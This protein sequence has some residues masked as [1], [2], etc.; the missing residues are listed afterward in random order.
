MPGNKKPRKKI[1]AVRHRGNPVGAAINA[2]KRQLGTALLLHESL[3]SVLDGSGSDDHIA[4]LLSAVHYY[5]ALIDRV[6]IDKTIEP[7]GIAV[8]RDILV[9][10][11]DA[12]AGV[13]ERFLKIGR[14][15]CTGQE[16]KDLC[17]LLELADILENETTLA[18]AREAAQ[19]LWSE[20]TS[21]DQQEKQS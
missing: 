15:G 19:R 18:Q 12:V 2:Q 3:A 1:R 6:E 13:Q 14:V 10:A 9:D 17:G 11:R 21:A 8:A 16:R 4:V 20:L 5:S 7:A